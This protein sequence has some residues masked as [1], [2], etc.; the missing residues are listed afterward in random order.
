[1]SLQESPEHLSQRNPDVW[2]FSLGSHSPH[3]AGEGERSESDLKLGRSA[4]PRGQAPSPRARERTASLPG[5]HHC[6]CA[7][8][9]TG[10]GRAANTAHRLAAATVAER[11]QAPPR[12]ASDLSTQC[13][14]LPT[15]LPRVQTG[16]LGRGSPQP[17]PRCSSCLRPQC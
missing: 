17:L 9:S 13:R 10:R 11:D 5:R 16:I 8:G 2:V 15:C 3:P 12:R 7:S 1:M 4:D 6:S 14:A